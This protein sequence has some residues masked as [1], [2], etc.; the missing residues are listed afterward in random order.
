MRRQ[1]QDVS[2]NHIH[3]LAP[4]ERVSSTTGHVVERTGPIGGSGSGRERKRK[5]FLVH[6]AIVRCVSGPE[7]AGF[8]ASVLL[9]ISGRI[10]W[11]PPRIETGRLTAR[12]L[13]RLERWSRLV[14]VGH[15]SLLSRNSRCGVERA[16]L[17]SGVIPDSRRSYNS[18][19][20]CES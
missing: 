9:A 19:L 17:F 14:R 5:L 10:D 18:S 15:R 4:Q 7:E 20:W 13:M 6:R 2:R 11:D 12:G 8:R 1:G 16:Q 3:S